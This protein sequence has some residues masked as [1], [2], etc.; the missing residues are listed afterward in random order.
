[1][2]IKKGGI[3]ISSLDDWAARAGPKSRDQWVDGRSAK[4]VARAWLD[5]GGCEL[6]PEVGNALANNPTFG[7]VESWVAE[8]E[9]KLRFDDF[10]GEPRNSDLVV[11]A[12]DSRGPY[13]I[14]VEAKADEPFGESV[15]DALASSL[16]RILENERS[17]ALLRIQQLAQALLGTRQQGDPPIKHLRYQLLT[18][19]A[20]AICEAERRQYSRAVVLIHEFV[21][22]KTSDERHAANSAALDAFVSRLTHGVVSH[23]GD[24]GIQGPFAVPNAM[25]F[26]G[27]VGLFVG[28]VS[29]NLR[30]AVS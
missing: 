1:M 22:N 8:P 26:A 10:A 21:S 15:A 7:P 20:G 18:A 11:Y 13:L 28:K 17:K 27:T 6:P 14:A 3:K 16:E 30:S 29:R 19:C 24:G 9:A 4:E 25:L 2:S 23:V 5:G 12:R